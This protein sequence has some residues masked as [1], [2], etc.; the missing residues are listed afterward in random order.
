MPGTSW[1][2][3]DIGTD[4]Q[5]D[6]R[7]TGRRDT[8]V[9]VRGLMEWPWDWAGSSWW[10]I[11]QGGSQAF[12]LH[13]TLDPRPGPPVGQPPWGL[14]QVSLLHLGVIGAC[15]LVGTHIA[16]VVQD[17]LPS[18]DALSLAALIKAF[19]VGARI[20]TGVRQPV[21]STTRFSFLFG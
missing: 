15:V 8:A 18:S 11:Q 19:F 7:E 12:L 4:S 17:V 13:V 6:D 1:G 9:W 21:H 2:G 20:L 10:Q 16:T 3:E 14:W 5:T